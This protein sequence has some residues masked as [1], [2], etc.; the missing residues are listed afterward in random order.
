MDGA[1]LDPARNVALR[2]NG[3]EMAR[4]HDGRV[5]LAVEEHVAVVVERPAGHELPYERDE[6]GLAA[7][8][9][10]H[11]DELERSGGDI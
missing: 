5:R 4:E 3:V 1:A 11:V 6:L 2:R 10:E 8:L 9:G 7:A